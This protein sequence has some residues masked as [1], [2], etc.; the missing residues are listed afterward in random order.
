M[1][2]KVQIESLSPQ[3]V[4]TLTREREREIE[5]VSERAKQLKSE[6]ERE[7]E[8]VSKCSLFQKQQKNVLS[9]FR[10]SFVSVRCDTR[11]VLS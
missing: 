5:R 3:H 6:R 8:L 2:K 4:K 7:R 10:K 9:T 1:N 11:L